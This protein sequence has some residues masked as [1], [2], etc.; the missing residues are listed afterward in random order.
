MSFHSRTSFGQSKRTIETKLAR[1]CGDKSPKG[2]L[3]E[4]IADLVDFINGHPEYVT[5]SSCSGRI[6]LF[7]TFEKKWILAKHGLVTPEETLTILSQYF[8]NSP[9]ISPVLLKHEPFIL[10]VQCIDLKAAER[11]LQ[12]VLQAGYRESGIVLG[13]KKIM[14]GV[15]TFS[16]TMEIPLNAASISSASGRG[17][18]KYFV[19]EACRRFVQNQEKT[20]S[21]FAKF[22]E[23]FGNVPTERSFEPCPV[24]IRGVEKRRL[25]RW[26]H[27]GAS[28]NRSVFIFGGY[29]KARDGH[30]GRLD[31]LL[32]GCWATGHFKDGMIWTAYDNDGAAIWP[33]PRVRHTLTSIG[34]KGDGDNS[35]LLV[36]FG[37]RGPPQKPFNDVMVAE[38]KS[39]CDQ[40]EEGIITWT[41]PSLHSDS[42]A[43]PAERWGHSA[44]CWGRSGHIFVHGGRNATRVF[45]D[46][47]SLAV[48]PEAYE[49]SRLSCSG[50]TPG[51]LFSHTATVTKA[52]IV[53]AGGYTSCQDSTRHFSKSVYVL[54]SPGPSSHWSVVDLEGSITSRYSHSAM[55]V[56]DNRIL[57]MGGIR[58]DGNSYGMGLFDTVNKQVENLDAGDFDGSSTCIR[59]TSSSLVLNSG[60]SVLVKVGGGSQCLSF[61]YAWDTPTV[62]AVSLSKINGERSELPRSAAEFRT[63][64]DQDTKPNFQSPGQ[65]DTTFVSAIVTSS[66]NV[67]LVKVALEKVNAL[68]LNY[69]ICSTGNVWKK[70]SDFPVAVQAIPEKDR[71]KWKL[72]PLTSN[73]TTRIKAAQAQ[74]PSGSPGNFLGDSVK[75]LMSN[76]LAFYALD[77]NAKHIPQ[78]KVLRK[79]KDTTQENIAKLLVRNLK[80]HGVSNGSQLLALLPQKMERLGSDVI[81]LPGEIF[82]QKRMNR[83]SWGEGQNVGDGKSSNTWNSLSDECL[84]AC[85]ADIARV[86]RVNRILCRREIDNGIMR[87]SC[88]NIIYDPKHIGTW[89]TIKENGVAY[90]FNCEEVMFCT[91][92]GTEKRRV[93]TFPCAE[94][95]V[96][97]LYAGIGYFTLPYL[98]HAKAKHLHACEINP[99]SVEALRKNLKLN[100]V[101]DRCTVYLG[102]NSQTAPKLRGIA[103]RVNLGLLPDSVKGYR[104]GLDCLN[105]ATGGVLH[106]H[107]N[108]LSKLREEWGK[109][110][111]KEIAV[112]LEE[113]WCENGSAPCTWRVA[114]DHVERVKSYAP[115]VDHVVADIRI[116]PN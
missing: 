54:S 115:R 35:H 48:T 104:L 74:A 60:E 108:C 24:K 40:T 7:A 106:V 11:L 53:I 3:D 34:D 71:K 29:G 113:A 92:N 18:V 6:V 99:A 110:T 95:V 65:D 51:P 25:Q 83:N 77:I 114:C 94:E 91:G 15:R 36:L 100:N 112:I 9:G 46:S 73:A 19:E 2:F 23:V 111:A 101:E 84:T 21:L 56:N 26:S 80:K 109:K 67:K 78:T 70:Q 55:L 52:S 1:A 87:K 103:Q 86:G 30:V 75:E 68:N 90:S 85:L 63:E 37:G 45:D 50:S 32:V 81:V 98:V 107:G 13:K 16:G 69:R 88:A 41:H 61:G 58:E 44:V 97:D 33:E 27:A 8:D 4:P 76:G 43:I 59:H 62:S 105:K 47:F 49:W 38:I 12:M 72:I 96:V 66:R 5:T 79:I 22:Q 10:H 20:D 64:E 17:M 14:V 89:I 102:D 93:G 39:S 31:D 82:G 57:L 116:T 42:N 28:N